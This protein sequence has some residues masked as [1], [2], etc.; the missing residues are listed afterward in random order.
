[1]SR[2]LALWAAVWL[3]PAQPADH[4]LAG[5]GQRYLALFVLH[6]G[7]QALRAPRL[8]FFEM[9][10][11]ARDVFLASLDRLPESE[12]V[13][14]V[15][16]RFVGTPYRLHPLGEG[17]GREPDPDPLIRF[18]AVD[19]TTFIEQTM[20]LARSRSALEGLYWLRR[21]RYV[22]G[23]VDYACRKHFMMAQ[24]LP[25]NQRAGF[26]EDIT[27][28]VGGPAA[29][30]VRKRL[31]ARIWSLR[32]PDVAWPELGPD[33]IPAGDFEL[34]ILPLDD[35]L[36]LVD[37]IPAGSLLSVVRR[38]LRNMPTRVTHQ[39]LLVQDGARPKLRHAGRAGYGLVV[40]EDLAH[41]IE[42][43]KAYR[44][45]PVEGINLQRIRMGAARTGEGK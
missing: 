1:M 44:R 27:V 14:A 23:R 35:V 39:G 40:D 21:I 15:S 33:Q 22:D 6:A 31:T 30:W 7:R 37:R 5:L 45:W 16:S 4:G 20:A 9:Q 43:N 32:K 11:L 34:P 2:L 12:R 36:R 17:P 25:L 29:R 38:D 19:C 3:S 24:W 26:L 8:P 28:Q 10:P 42:R 41:F 18:D 13:L